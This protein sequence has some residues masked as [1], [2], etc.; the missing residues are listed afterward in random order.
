MFIEKVH[1]IV[2]EQMKTCHVN[3]DTVAMKMCITNQQLRRRILAITGQTG[4]VYILG[5]RINYA[6]QLLSGDAQLPIAMVARKCGYDDSNNFS[7]T[8]KRVVGMTPTEFIR[9]NQQ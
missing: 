7:R 5:I 8:F 3:C 9:K 2:L 1:E 6:K 4:G